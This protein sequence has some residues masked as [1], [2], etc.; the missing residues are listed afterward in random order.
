MF[1]YFEPKV[2]ARVKS[3]STS[4]FTLVEMIVAIAIFLIV[5]FTV[6]G[7]FVV[8]L[9]A[10][11]KAQQ[12]NLITENINYAL[13]RMTINTNE[14]YN[15]IIN[16]DA[17]GN[18][19][20]EMSLSDGSTIKYELIDGKILENDAPLTSDKI[21]IDKLIFT[22]TGSIGPNMN[23]VIVTINIHG[24]VAFRQGVTEIN[25]QTTAAQRN[26]F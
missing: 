20:L 6:T 11:R 15:Y 24:Q 18:N 13:N 22:K 10:Y 12:V 2:D 8:A 4:G 9:D 19:T 26:T 5:A 25:I 16:P 17:S 1:F 21:T 14:G 23:N 3:K 7:T